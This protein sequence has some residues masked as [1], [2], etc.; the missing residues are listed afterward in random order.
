MNTPS[1]LAEPIGSTSAAN[2]PGHASPPSSRLWKAVDD[3]RS[4]SATT[5]PTS[6]PAL[7]THRSAHRRNHSYGLG[8]KTSVAITMR[9]L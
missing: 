6:C 8:C 4:R 9:F 5:S 2:R 3:S 1:H 7:R